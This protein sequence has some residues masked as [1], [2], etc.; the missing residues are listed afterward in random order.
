MYSERPDEFDL[1]LKEALF[2]TYV[3]KFRARMENFNVSYQF[4]WEERI[5]RSFKT[6][7]NLP[8]GEN[9]LKATV[10]ELHPVKFG[11]YARQLLAEAREAAEG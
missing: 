9:R 3:I 8:Q 7:F 10:M 11:E 6:S 5:P 1:L 2:R 4:H